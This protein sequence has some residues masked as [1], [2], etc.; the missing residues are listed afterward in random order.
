MIRKR[1]RAG[2]ADAIEIRRQKILSA[3]KACASRFGFHA[4]SVAQIA[5]AAGLSVG[6]I[7]RY[8]ESKEAVIAAVVAERWPC[9]DLIAA[10]LGGPPIGAE[11]SS[12]ADLV[13]QPEECLTPE[14][15]ALSLEIWAEAARNPR[16]AAIVRDARAAEVARTVKLLSDAGGAARTPA[17]LESRA[18]LLHLLIEGMQV[19]AVQPPSNLSLVRERVR[20]LAAQLAA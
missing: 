3:A 4:T 5:K 11:P 2:R 9:A 6:Q 7:Y 13:G 8:F 1:E 17:D 19:W 10:W 18:E 20:Q 14:A 15:A 16:V 12:G